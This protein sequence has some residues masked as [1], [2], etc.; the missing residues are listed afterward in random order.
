MNPPVPHY[1]LFSEPIGGPQGVW[2]FVLRSIQGTDR[3]EASDEEPGVRG[4]RLELL[5][6]VRGL[7]ALDQPSKVTLMTPSKYV[8]EG[9]RYGLS[10]WRSNGWRWE[11]YGE[12]V[13]VKNRDLWQRVD[14]AM[15]FHEVDCRQWR[16]DAAHGADVMR[17]VVTEGR[18]NVE[19]PNREA[20]R[21]R[22]R[23]T[24]SGGIRGWTRRLSAAVRRLAAGP[25]C[26]REGLAGDYGSG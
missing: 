12:M 4:D 19:Q 13:P 10:E 14:R 5:T 23:T 8:R 15:R 7:E 18:P 22:D 1:F 16:F 21:R 6:V 24:R 2:K 25:P 9:I 26:G 3:F 20:N 11:F 17:P